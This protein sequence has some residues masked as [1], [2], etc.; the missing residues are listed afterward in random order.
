M[1]K[2]DVALLLSAINT[3][4]DFLLLLEKR[5]LS[6]GEH[7]SK[8]FQLREKVKQIKLDEPVKKDLQR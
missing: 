1:D 6:L 2:E 8:F 4:V 7:L 3:E 5:G